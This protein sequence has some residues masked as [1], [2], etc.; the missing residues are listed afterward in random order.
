MLHHPELFFKKLTSQVGAPKE[1]KK[2]AAK[3]R[4]SASKR[5]AQTREEQAI[6]EKHFLIH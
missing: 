1:E 3:G 2:E 4:K 6:I 5:F